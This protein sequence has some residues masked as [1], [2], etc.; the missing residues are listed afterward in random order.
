ML[1]LVIANRFIVAI[2][3]SFG[4]F[5]LEQD[6]ETLIVYILFAEDERGNQDMQ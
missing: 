4:K 5:A 1:Q 3:T 2:V 6:D